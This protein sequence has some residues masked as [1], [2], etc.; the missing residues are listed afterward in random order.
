M[1][2]PKVYVTG[3]KKKDISRHPICLTDYDYNYI[4]EEI[5]RWGKIDF[6]R[7]VEIYSDDKEN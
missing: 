4:L 7:D 1:T 2:Y 3:H 6:E 5:G